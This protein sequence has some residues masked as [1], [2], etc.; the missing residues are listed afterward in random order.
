MRI[1][2]LK[3]W[4]WAVIG[5]LVGTAVAWIWSSLQA[6]GGLGDSV[7][8]GSEQFERGLNA[9]PLGGHPKIKNIT[10]HENE[11]RSSV[12]MKVL[13]PDPTDPHPKNPRHYRYVNERLN[14]TSP[15]LPA[16]RES[17]SQT[18]MWRVNPSAVASAPSAGRHSS[19]PLPLWINGAAIQSIF[20]REFSLKDWQIQAGQWSDPGAG[21]DLNLPLRPAS[22]QMMVVLSRAQEKSVSADGLSI[23]FNGK[24][25]P[26]LVAAK[27]SSGF[28]LETTIPREAFTAGESQTLRFS[29]KNEPVKVWEVRLID[30]TYSILDYLNY[31]KQKHPDLSFASAWWD[32]PRVKYPLCG[33]IGLVFFGGVWPTL[34]KLLIGAESR[35]AGGP[36][37]DLDRFHG[38]APRE[39][40][41]AMVPPDGDE[42]SD[43]EDELRKSLEL[44]NVASNPSKSAA[45]PA[46][47]QLTAEPVAPIP[48]ANPDHLAH[49]EGEYYPV[50][51]P[52]VD[53]DEV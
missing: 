37:Y 51:R 18:V 30:P 43:L 28:T 6:S 34:I 47:V 39:E 29:R 52:I 27:K 4:Q 41:V 50:V 46:P 13:E 36:K 3:R 20:V 33:V 35:Q 44:Q 25:L 9:Q 16:W 15:F 31:A 5:L 17:P 42:L 22:Y 26:P 1:E 21:A 24:P 10:V 11:G 23:T 12:W 7:T 45:A 40:P 8:L 19:G 2:Y 53:K 48:A 49:Y 38:D 14:P 32:A